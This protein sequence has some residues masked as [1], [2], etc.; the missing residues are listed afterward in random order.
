VLN[1]FDGI[2][3]MA[4][5]SLVINCMFPLEHF[6]DEIR[7]IPVG[8]SRESETPPEEPHSPENFPEAETV[9]KP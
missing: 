7:S 9:S 8:L 1:S 6:I 3:W 5:R 2:D 4:E